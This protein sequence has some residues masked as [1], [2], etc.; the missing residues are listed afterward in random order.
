[1]R[2]TFSTLELAKRALQTQ[3]TAMSV[4]GHN[5]ANANSPGY[6]RQEVIMTATGP[7]TSPS[8]IRPMKAGQIGTGVSIKSI[9]R[10]FDRYVSNQWRLE[11][12]LLS[13]WKMK[14]S[15][16]TQI[17]A[18]FNEPSNSSLRMAIDDFWSALQ[19]L[20]VEP[21]ELSSR[22]LVRQTGITMV[23]SFKTMDRQLTQVHKDFDE[24]Q[25]GSVFEI[26]S[27]LDQIRDVNQRIVRVRAMGD[28]PN[29]LM[30]QRD[31]LL[32][33]LTE[34]IPIEMT[35]RGNGDL[36]ISFQGIELVNYTTEHEPTPR[37]RLNDAGLDIVQ[38]DDAGNV[39]A[40][41]LDNTQTRGAIMDGHG[42]LKG[43]F[44]AQDSIEKY[45]GYLNNYVKTYVDELNAVHMQ[46]YGT[47]NVTGTPFF[48][49][50]T[51]AENIISSLQ[52]NPDII[53]NL[54]NIAAASEP[55]KFGDGSNALEFAKVRHAEVLSFDGKAVNFDQYYRAFIAEL[56]IEAN[57]T[58]QYVENQE[59]LA[60]QFEIRQESIRGVSIDEEMT[61]MVQYQHSY[62]A[63]ARLTTAID[64]MIETIVSRLGIVGR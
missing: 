8:N 42:K 11:N 46:G 52:V 14:Q 27:L 20:A 29:D 60:Y 53:S 41:I 21:T 61:K 18:I 63:A 59:I 4:V 33:R 22:A 62:N 1:M 47:N 10:Q 15:G 26:N 5:I 34:I 36:K 39:T 35:D 50:D 2:S 25:K 16:M 31:L 40:V 30:D 23:D 6:S 12:S 49:Y 56:G 58:N 64:E 43:V 51:T 28:M 3:H 17:E 24:I 55:D 7:Y 48:L 19:Q 54:N 37:F 45:R 38:Y 13:Q 44:Q 57:E 32:D 9:E